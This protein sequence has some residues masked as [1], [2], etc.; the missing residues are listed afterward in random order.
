MSSRGRVDRGKQ[1]KKGIETDDAR[2]RREETTVQLRKSKRE[3]SLMKRRKDQGLAAAE[4]MAPQGPALVQAPEQG[5][6]Q[7]IAEMVAAV[8][9]EDPQRQRDA[10]VRFRKLLSI[11]KH[12]FRTLTPRPRVF[13]SLT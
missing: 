11:G 3:D 5:A 6:V 2:R 4:P 10:T 9:S 12:T 13:C 8:Q 7:D 1:Y